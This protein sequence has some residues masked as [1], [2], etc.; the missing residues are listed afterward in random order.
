MADNTNE[1]LNTQI[2]R[3]NDAIR[4]NTEAQEE[5]GALDAIKSIN[6]LAVVTSIGSMILKPIMS[7]VKSV[8]ALQQTTLSL[9]INSED[10][11]ANLR[12]EIS[13]LPGGIMT[14]MGSV[15]TMMTA[16]FKNFDRN[17]IKL[18][19]QAELT[20]QSS[21]E[22]ARGF[23][24][25]AAGVPL[26][27]DKLGHLA[28]RT[29]ELSRTYKIRTTD[30]VGALE[31]NTD[32]LAILNLQDRGA[33]VE[34]AVLEMT[35]EAGHHHAAT[36]QKLFKMTQFADGSNDLQKAMLHLQ[37]RKLVNELGK[38]NITADLMKRTV[39]RLLEVAEH[40]LNS[41]GDQH[42]FIKA[43]MAK[44]F[45]QD[46]LNLSQLQAVKKALE[47][48]GSKERLASYRQAAEF[49]NSFKAMMLKI[50][51]PLQELLIPAIGFVRDHAGEL[52]HS[53]T[54][55]LK[56]AITKVW[57]FGE[58]AAGAV[59]SIGTFLKQIVTNV[60]TFAEWIPGVSGAA[61]AM[62][63]ILAQWKND[64]DK[65]FAALLAKVDAMMNYEKEIVEEAKQRNYLEEK[66]Q[67]GDD[68]SVNASM[69][70]DATRLI[71][72][73]TTNSIFR[74]TEEDNN[75]HLKDIVDI[76]L[77]IDTNTLKTLRAGGG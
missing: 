43:E 59:V 1:E 42:A 25:I 4:A 7:F 44:A 51:S 70:D 35:A 56:V 27:T 10:L 60:L 29:A 61:K 9:G 58:I 20:G 32:T 2:Q 34:E 75:K 62:N 33:G 48:E 72:E 64:G 17:T 40:Q 54:G 74:R 13:D 28:T 52:V 22:L 53:I 45:G 16:G 68:W 36:I 19:N 71:M 3:L 37:N 39:H 57:Y 76:L 12:T 14:S 47:D 30:L 26:S 23:A 50:I 73:A 38:G 21:A 11:L 24:K 41:G 31:S 63:H 66:K 77:N 5:G 67:R 49:D 69:A 6:P 65:H 8:E 18:L 55:W 46:Q 15:T